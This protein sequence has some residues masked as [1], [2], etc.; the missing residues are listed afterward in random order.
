MN[1]EDG[2][3]DRKKDYLE[4]LS[5]GRTL[6][7]VTLLLVAIIRLFGVERWTDVSELSTLKGFAKLF[8]GTLS[9]MFG[10]FIVFMIGFVLWDLVSEKMDQWK[11]TRGPIGPIVKALVICLIATY[12]IWA[13][14]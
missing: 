1:G 4:T 14:T 11:F 9:A 3:K 13:M 12:L 5:A 8:F 7:G 10:A 6:A 2:K